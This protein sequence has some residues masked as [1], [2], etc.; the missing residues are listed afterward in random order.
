MFYFDFEV[1]SHLFDQLLAL[2]KV[3]QREALDYSENEFDFVVAQEA[4]HPN[5]QLLPQIC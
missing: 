5:Y 1:F 3:V 2:V 4:H